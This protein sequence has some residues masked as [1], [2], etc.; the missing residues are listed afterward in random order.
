MLVLFVVKVMLAVTLFIQQSL[1][2][3]LDLAEM[4]NSKLQVTNVVNNSFKLK[5]S[6]V[7][8]F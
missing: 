5:Y 4:A 3:Y 2:M 6:F 8:C 1:I 7:I